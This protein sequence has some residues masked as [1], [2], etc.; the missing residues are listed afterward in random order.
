MVFSGGSRRSPLLAKDTQADDEAFIFDLR[1]A[2][3]ACCCL[4]MRQLEGS[5]PLL[6]IV[7]TDLITDRIPCWKNAS[8]VALSLVYVKADANQMLDPVRC[9]QDTSQPQLTDL[10]NDPR[11][12]H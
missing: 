7:F 3:F 10:Y 11:C 6:R 12:R 9:V 1:N 8:E 4:E 5:P 2:V